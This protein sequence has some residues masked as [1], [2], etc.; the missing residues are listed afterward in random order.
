MESL[1]WNK[2]SLVRSALISVSD[3]ETA[4]VGKIEVDAGDVVPADNV[5]FMREEGDVVPE[6]ELAAV[7][8]EISSFSED[9][10]GAAVL[11]TQLNSHKRYYRC[12]EKLSKE[13]SWSDEIK[14]KNIYLRGVWM[15]KEG[16]CCSIICLNA[17][18]T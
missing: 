1:T 11:K 10:G 5:E 6:S 16:S 2:P 15:R 8:A 17:N 14:L 18:K 13:R 4:L 3:S 9:G 7:N 12:R